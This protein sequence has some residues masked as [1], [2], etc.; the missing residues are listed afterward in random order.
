MRKKE[1]NKLDM[2]EE[3]ETED[4]EGS[5]EEEPDSE[6]DY[7]YPSRLNCTGSEYEEWRVKLE[8]KNIRE[9]ESKAKGLVVVER[10][11][12]TEESFFGVKTNEKT[13]SYAEL[14][15]ETADKV[16]NLQGCLDD[17]G[18]VVTNEG[19]RF[20]NC[21]WGWMEKITT[22]EVS[23][24]HVKGTVYVKHGHE[25][26]TD[27]TSFRGC[28]YNQGYCSTGDEMY[29]RWE[30]RPE[31]KESF[32]EVGSYDAVQINGHL[33]IEALGL[34]IDVKGGVNVTK[35]VDREFRVTKEKRKDQVV[36]ALNS[37]EES[38]TALRDE[39]NSRFEYLVELIKSP[40]AQAIY[41]CKVWNRLRMIEKMTAIIDPTTYIREKTG[42]NLLVGRRAGD[43]VV[44]YPCV[45]KTKLSWIKK[46]GGKC[47]DG[48]PV[49]FEV[50]GSETIHKGFLLPRHN[51]IEV[52]GI[53]V[54]CHKKQP[55]ITEV[56]G[57]LEWRSAQ[58][59]DTHVVNVSN[60]I[61]LTNQMREG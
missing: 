55:I 60:V 1:G 39:L 10:K 23:C 5:S 17:K 45:E 47:Y 56:R 20:Y 53:E 36:K 59:E 44:A 41:L 4:E 27:L 40:K 19:K 35:W 57:K 43:Y 52:M 54:N 7:F 50:N 28:N 32:E 21:K 49:K 2:E 51:K 26:R 16:M 11:C 9:Y 8:K 14:T 22:V 6:E 37:N 61:D 33:L 31:V 13:M 42:N 15:K 3:S 48:L 30:V 38:I 58:S 29:L 24:K 46:T 25:A 12:V 34:V 18:E